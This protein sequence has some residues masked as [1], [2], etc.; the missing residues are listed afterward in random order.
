MLGFEVRRDV[1][2]PRFCYDRLVNIGKLS[3]A[4]CSVLFLWYW[5]V[6]GSQC[7]KNVIRH[8]RVG[9]R[10]FDMVPHVDDE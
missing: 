8:L 7:V 5:Y 4:H 2:V 9:S 6:T 3:M 1:F 10:R